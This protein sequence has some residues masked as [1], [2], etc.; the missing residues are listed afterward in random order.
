MYKFPETMAKVNVEGISFPFDFSKF[1]NIMSTFHDHNPDIAWNVIGYHETEDFSKNVHK[2]TIVLPNASK[3]QLCM[4]RQK[5]VLRN[6]FPLYMFE[7]GDRKFN[8]DLLLLISPDYTNSHFVLIRNLEGLLR[9]NKSMNFICRSC[10]SPFHSES[11]FRKHKLYCTKRSAAVFFPQQRHI[12]FENYRSAIKVPFTYYL[13]TE[14]YLAAP[15]RNKSSYRI[16]HEH[17]ATAYSYCCVSDKGSMIC[18]NTYVQKTQSE[19][20]IQIMLEDLMGDI[21]KRIETL[22]EYQRIASKTINMSSV[23]L[24]NILN[25]KD[26]RYRECCFCKKFFT[27]HEMETKKIVAHHSHTPDFEFLVLSCDRH[28]LV[29]RMT[30]FLITVVIH[31][32]SAYDFSYIIENLDVLGI[33]NIDIIPKSSQKFLSIICH[34]KTQGY[35]TQ[36]RFID[37]F[38][39]LSAGLSNLCEVVYENGHGAHKFELIIEAFKDEIKRG[40]VLDDLMHKS[41]FPYKLL[42]SFESLSLCEFRDSCFF[43]DEIKEIS[44]NE[45][46]LDR[47][48]SIWDALDIKNLRQLVRFYCKL[49]T[50]ILACVFEAFRTVLFNAFNLDPLNFLHCLHL[51]FQAH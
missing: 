47:A 24:Q 26:K 39:F 21:R 51:H 41:L 31:N 37:S 12:K 29:S 27:K 19:N 50:I 44:V 46:D 10:L 33:D 23:N 35:H 18:S 34:I 2:E 1:E 43:F 13:D 28:N 5:R 49:D 40:L 6:C 48:R 42:T 4:S 20:V 11:S 16:V 38:Q 15:S 30:P 22:I 3:W 8:V 17:K 7:G 36:I 14:S 45:S 32:G 9:L 25:N